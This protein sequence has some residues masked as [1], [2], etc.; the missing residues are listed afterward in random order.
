MMQGFTAFIELH[1]LHHALERPIYGL[2][3]IGE[4][5]EHGYK[6]SPGTLYPL[7]HSMEKL[8]LL[9]SRDV[10]ANGR[11]R[12]YYSITSK[13][14]RYLLKGK[15]HIAELANELFD[16]EDFRLLRGRSRVRPA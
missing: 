10:L 2:W 8:G 16:A 7:L 13:G 4:L 11:I 6:I 15:R 5:A 14:K 1:I 3:L 9:K 12:K